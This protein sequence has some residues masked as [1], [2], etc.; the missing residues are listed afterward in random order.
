MKNLRFLQLGW[1]VAAAL[2]AVVVAGG[3]QAA[4][5]K[6]GVVDISNVIEKSDFGKA[7]QGSFD[8][9]KSARETLLVFVDNNRVLTEEQA[10]NLKDL[11][12]KPNPTKEDTAKLESLKADVIAAAKK[13]QE[14][15]TKANMSPEERTL[16]EE[17]A[18]RSQKMEETAQRWY[19]EFTSDMQKWADQQ[20][21]ES[22]DKAR[23]A[24]QDVAKAEG[25]TVILEVGIAPYGA[26]DISAEVLAKMNEKK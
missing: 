25:F 11:W 10:Q 18:R 23:A 12:L 22:L 5:L 24:I 3:F 16:I 1:I 9:M 13:S 19:R 14:L 4:P 7:N 20:K 6:V 26:N 17:Y 2:F 15:A 21:L 8:A